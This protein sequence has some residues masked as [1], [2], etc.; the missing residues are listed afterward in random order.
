MELDS[1]SSF[2]ALG[3]SRLLFTILKI[4]VH[5]WAGQ[6]KDRGS[7]PGGRKNFSLLHSVQCKHILEFDQAF[8]HCA[9]IALPPRALTYSMEQSPNML[10]TFHVPNLMSLFRCLERTGVSEQVRGS[11]KHF[12][13]G[14]VFTVRSYHLAQY[15]SR[16]TTPYRLFATAYST[17]SQVPTILEDVLP[18]AT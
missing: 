13:T 12:V 2:L 14:Y 9:T 16:R 6:E 17:Y 4:F 11:F 3:I 8:S 7:S 10:L 1:L 5:S 18:S 15:S